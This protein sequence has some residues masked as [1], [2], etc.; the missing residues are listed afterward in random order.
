MLNLMKK[1]QQRVLLRVIDPLLSFF[2]FFSIFRQDI[3]ESLMA[4]NCTIWNHITHSS[5]NASALNGD[6]VVPG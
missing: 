5:P 1:A 4:I 6:A 3:L 2:F